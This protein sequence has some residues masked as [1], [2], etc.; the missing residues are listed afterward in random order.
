MMHLHS[1]DEGWMAIEL[2]AERLEPVEIRLADESIRPAVWTGAQWWS[3]GQ[4]VLPVAWRPIRRA[5][6][7]DSLLQSA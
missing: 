2:P 6:Q 5:E 7:A 3:E 4:E 1:T